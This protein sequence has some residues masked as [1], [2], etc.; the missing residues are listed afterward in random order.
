MAIFLKLLSL[1]SAT[2]T[3]AF[4]TTTTGCAC[5]KT[6]TAQNGITVN[7][8]CGNPDN[9][10]G[11]EWCFTECN[12]GDSRCGREGWGYCAPAGSRESSTSTCTASSIGSTFCSPSSCSSSLVNGVQFGCCCSGPHQGSYCLECAVGS[13]NLRDAPV[14]PAYTPPPP[15]TSPPPSVRPPPPTTTPTSTASS[16]PPVSLCQAPVGSFCCDD[17]PAKPNYVCGAGSSCGRGVCVP[18]GSILCGCSGQHYCPAGHTCCGSTCCPTTKFCGGDENSCSCSSEAF[19]RPKDELNCGTTVGSFC[20]QVAGGVN[21]EDCFPADAKVT[22]SNGT[23]VRIDSLR[24]GDT[25]L[26]ATVDGRLSSDEVTLFSIAMPKAVAPFI[27]LSTSNATLKLTPEHHLPVGPTCCNSLKKAKD[28]VVG[29]VV[30]TA[31]TQEISST[32]VTRKSVVNGVG[33]HSPVLMNGGFPIV[34]G[35]VTSFDSIEQVSLARKGLSSVVGACTASG[36][37]KLFRNLF[38]GG[39]EKYIIPK[40]L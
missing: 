22:L 39:D 2:A 17:D 10:P 4:R 12:F 40:P 25:M 37:C 15:F 34:D 5:L 3:V 11:G 29:D 32:I 36:T 30:W 18:A 13:C 23:I 20:N 1:L 7:D 33:L 19:P 28:V 21:V 26:A 9:D 14:S 16:P 8:Y 38:F 6:W 27:S 35:L 24:N 31:Q